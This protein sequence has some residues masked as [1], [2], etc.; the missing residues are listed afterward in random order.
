MRSSRPGASCWIMRDASSETGGG[1][2][3]AGPDGSDMD[4]ALALRAG[5]GDEAAFEA[6]VSRWWVR[7]GRLCAA[8]AGYDSQVADELAGDVLL[9]LYLGLPRYRG[10]SAFGTW[11]WGVAARAAA[12]WRRKTWRERRRLVPLARL[13]WSRTAGD[14]DGEEHREPVDPSLG[15]EAELLRGEEVEAVKRAMSRLSPQERGLVHLAEVEGLCGRELS[16]ALGLPEG[17]VKS[18]LHRARRKLGR[19]LEEDGHEA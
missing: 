10:D 16:I 1:R 3:G 12:D 9:R 11:L 19:L 2:R 4:R 17:T 5:A 13:S 6:L 18:R 14:P 8:H 15:P 7:I